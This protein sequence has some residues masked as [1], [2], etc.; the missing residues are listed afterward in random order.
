M[1]EAVT[2][3]IHNTF[4]DTQRYTTYFTIHCNQTTE[5]HSESELKVIVQQKLQNNADLD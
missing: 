1:V 4:Y 5:L 3:F 2:T